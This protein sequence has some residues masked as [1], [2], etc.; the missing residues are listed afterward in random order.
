[1]SDAAR[2]RGTRARRFA[3]V[4]AILALGLVCASCPSDTARGHEGR[5]VL[6]IAIDSLRGDHL[7]S[8]GYD[9]Q[10]TPMLDNL[11]NQGVLFEQTFGVAPEY[12][13]AHAGLLT[14]CDPWICR[15]PSHPDQRGT[16]ISTEWWLPNAIPNLAN[17]FLAAGYATAAFV[18]HPWISPTFGFDRGFQEFYRFRE[19]D[20]VG[21]DDY[22]FEGVVLRFRRW[23]R[24]QDEDR[25]WFAYLSITDLDRSWALEDEPNEGGFTPRPELDWVPPTS[26]LARTYFAIPNDGRR[27]RSAGV[28]TLGEYEVRYDSTLRQLD[29]RIGRML[30]ELGREGR[31][32][33]T[34]ICIV[35]TFGVG[36]G[37]SGLVLDT[38]TLSDVDMH[39]PWIL[40]PAAGARVVRG[41][42]RSELASVLDVAPTLLELAEIPVPDGMHGKSHLSVLRGS[43]DIVRDRAY[44]R[45]GI[46]QGFAVRD[47]R[48]TF[49]RT[50]PGTRGPR[51]LRISWSGDPD[52]ASVPYTNFLRDRTAPGG[53]GNLQPGYD[54]VER[55][56]LLRA[57]GEQWYRWI[58]AAREVVHETPWDREPIDPDVLRELVENGIVAP[59]AQSAP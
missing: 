28:A 29:K 14:G 17:E 59:R 5:G 55:A 13:P 25:D 58:D 15:R 20:V 48:F 43:E 3:S 19:D 36:F 6:L 56:E 12:L 40:R 46:Q 57:D 32:D 51:G 33:N 34:T 23:R 26:E 7:S 37:E 52:V 11:A 53:P 41:Q 24:A 44:S 42:R 50:A 38:G 8:M 16:G 10:T 4:L 39:V 2:V 30:E 18:D 45:G 31:L 49:E 27:I 35:G 21:Y 1:M 9:R 47:P 54:D 22:G